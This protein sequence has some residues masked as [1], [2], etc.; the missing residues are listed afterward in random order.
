MI[1]GVD[2]SFEPRGAM[3]WENEVNGGGCTVMEAAAESV[4]GFNNGTEVVADSAGAS[5]PIL[6]APRGPQRVLYAY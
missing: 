2:T 1:F 6:K 3:C 4:E 5:V